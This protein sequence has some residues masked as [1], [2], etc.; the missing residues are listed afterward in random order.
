MCIKQFSV[1]STI[2]LTIHYMTRPLLLIAFA[3]INIQKLTIVGTWSCSKSRLLLKKQEIISKS[4]HHA[5]KNAKNCPRALPFVAPSC[6]QKRNLAGNS[7]SFDQTCTTTL[8]VVYC[9]LL[10]K[11]VASFTTHFVFCS[12]SLKHA[13]TTNRCMWTTY[14]IHFGIL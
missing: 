7:A 1:R 12:S 5:L 13:N 14:H 10:F 6:L 2:K 3:I 4:L 8:E 11:F 9:S